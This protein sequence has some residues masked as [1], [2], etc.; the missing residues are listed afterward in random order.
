MSILSIQFNSVMP[1]PVV[2]GVSCSSN[3]TQLFASKFE[4]LLNTH[5]FLC[6]ELLCNIQSGLSE[7]HLVDVSV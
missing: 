5:S 2:D 6:N 3:I 1:L 7:S 4:S